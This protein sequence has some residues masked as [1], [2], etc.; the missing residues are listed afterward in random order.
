[1]P[2]DYAEITRAVRPRAV[3]VRVEPHHVCGPRDAGLEVPAVA[4]LAD[5]MTWWCSVTSASVRLATLFRI[6]MLDAVALAPASQRALLFLVL[7]DLREFTPEQALSCW[8]ARLSL[9]R[10]FNPALDNLRWLVDLTRALRADATEDQRVAGWSALLGEFTPRAAI[11]RAALADV[12]WPTEAAV[13][14]SIDALAST[15]ALGSVDDRRAAVTTLGVFAAHVPER[16]RTIAQH[17]VGALHDSERAVRAAAAVALREPALAQV[18]DDGDIL[19]ALEAGLHDAD[20]G[21]RRQALESLC[22]VGDR[23]LARHTDLLPS[24]SRLARFGT[25]PAAPFDVKL[26]RRDA[27]ACLS[28]IARNT[29]A[30]RV[31]VLT[32]LSHTA[33]T[34]VWAVRGATAEALGAIGSAFPGAARDVMRPLCKLALDRLPPVARHAIQA[35]R[36]VCATA[37]DVTELA[38]PTLRAVADRN[39]ALHRVAMDALRG[40]GVVYTARPH[41]RLYRGDVRR[42][43]RHTELDLWP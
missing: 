33:S 32:T 38:L 3:R 7:G 23:A 35:L 9:H 18:D 22:H 37:E 8:I 13:A 39:D 11:E 19:R 21:V 30:A 36:V 24:L 14:I 6:G 29:P 4:S 12:G 28:I 41:A 25:E 20:V 40:L 31:A 1:M 43:D 26:K 27:V 17:V 34:R 10:R 42:L 2:I 5:L 15:L 16:G